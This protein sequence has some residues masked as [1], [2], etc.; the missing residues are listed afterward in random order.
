MATAMTA[1]EAAKLINGLVQ[2]VVTG[3]DGKPVIDKAADGAKTYRT[4]KVP[5]GAEHVMS[6][7]VRGD[8]VVVVTIDGQKL[9]APLPTEKR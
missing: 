7:A 4:K 5:V 1:A 9:T 2:V 8:R 3:A 6:F